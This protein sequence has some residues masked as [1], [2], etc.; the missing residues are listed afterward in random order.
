MEHTWP[1]SLGTRYP[2]VSAGWQP[3][4]Q[5]TPRHES[6][7]STGRL[8][9]GSQPKCSRRDHQARSEAR[10]NGHSLTGDNMDKATDTFEKYPNIEKLME[11]LM[12]IKD[13]EKIYEAIMDWNMGKFLDLDIH[14]LIVRG[15][16]T[17][18]LLLMKRAGAVKIIGDQVSLAWDPAMEKMMN[19]A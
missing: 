8:T 9:Y 14:E 11:H 17:H 13:N 16:L 5:D 3:E 15:S 2:A 7:R 12:S 19:I 1:H 18:Q 6:S 4:P 10:H